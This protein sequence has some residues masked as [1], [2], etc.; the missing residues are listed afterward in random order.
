MKRLSLALLFGFIGISMSIV[1]CSGDST[2]PSEPNA[3]AAPALDLRP[4]GGGPSEAAAGAAESPEAAA[5]AERP[6]LVAAIRGPAEIGYLRPETKTDGNE[7]VTTFQI[8]NLA[9]GA[10]AG[11][12]IDEFWY[13][14]NGN[15]LGGASE[16]LRQPLMPGEE[17][18][19]ELRVPSSPQ[20]NRSN[21]TF[22]HQNG[23]INATELAEFRQEGES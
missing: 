17:V 18:T 1:A 4:T 15:P 3:P 19:V 5:P 2:P 11:L 6:R 12:K 7:I 8:K 16:R 23:D 21:Y 9:T 10:I 20:M 13:D 14:R 22:S